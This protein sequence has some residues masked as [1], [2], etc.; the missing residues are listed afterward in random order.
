MNSINDYLRTENILLN[1]KSHYEWTIKMSGN[2]LFGC[3]PSLVEFDTVDLKFKKMGIKVWV[4]FSGNI[5]IA[6]AETCEGDRKDQM[7]E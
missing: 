2:R 6:G 4:P 7:V 3:W 5:V 1:S